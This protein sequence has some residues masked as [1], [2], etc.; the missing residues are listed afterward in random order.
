M[1]ISIIFVEK[2]PPPEKQ[3]QQ[4]KSQKKL[5]NSTR[6]ATGAEPSAEKVGAQMKDSS[7]LDDDL[8][9]KIYELTK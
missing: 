1:K 7:N 5:E 2:S 4:Q 9:V 8:G 3:Q 6:K